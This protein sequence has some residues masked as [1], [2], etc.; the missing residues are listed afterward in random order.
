MKYKNMR[1]Y[2]IKKIKDLIDNW[3]EIKEEKEAS[4]QIKLAKLRGVKSS[5]RSVVLVYLIYEKKITRI[6]ELK[7]NKFNDF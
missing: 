5:L 1:I 2:Q 3:I 6:K 7:Y 4:G